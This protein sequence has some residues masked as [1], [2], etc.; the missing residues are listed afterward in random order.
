MSPSRPGMKEGRKC[1]AVSRQIRRA[2]HHPPSRRTR[3]FWKTTRKKCWLPSSSSTCSTETLAKR[4][5]WHSLRSPKDR[6]EPDNG[7][8]GGDNGQASTFTMNLLCVRECVTL[9]ASSS[10]LSTLTR[11]CLHGRRARTWQCEE[12]A[13][14]SASA[15]APA[16]A[17]RQSSSSRR[18]HSRFGC[19]CSSSPP[20]MKKARAKAAWSE[21]PQKSPGAPRRFLAV[22]QKQQN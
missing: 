9:P 6:G 14:T 12:P 1:R 3:V 19:C 5:R 22:S 18:L 16:A 7:V 11:F 8:G 10:L 17:A 2:T 13:A 15:P 21:F 4:A 20:P